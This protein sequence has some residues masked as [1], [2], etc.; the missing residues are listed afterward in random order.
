[1]TEQRFEGWIAGLGS[2]SGVRVVVGW[3]Q[4]TPWGEFADVMVED[5]AGHRVLLAPDDRV[6]EL[7]EQTYNFDE[8]VIGPVQVAA[9]GRAIRVH[10][11]DLHLGFTVGGRTWL[12]GLLG[13]VPRRL[14]TSPRWLTVIDAAARVMLKGVRTRGSA[15]AGRTEFYGAYGLHRIDCLFGTWR[16]T[17]LG[18]LAP[19]QPPVRFGF[20]ST[21]R[22]PV[23]T[24]LV[25]TIRGVQ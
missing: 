13:L 24:S 23:V 4:Q 12:G 20:G 19:V 5:L 22:Q 14:A 9:L 3:W 10:G 25:T 6:A 8:V 7:L 21:P 1:L 18:T 17:D 2:T 11:R 16:G 15:G